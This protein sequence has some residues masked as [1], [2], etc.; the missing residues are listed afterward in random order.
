MLPEGLEL[1]PKQLI[2]QKGQFELYA[3]KIRGYR[4]V[5]QSWV[6]GG[7]I[8]EVVEAAGGW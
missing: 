5:D 7:V 6:G 4:T 3:A 1:L 2:N 8:H